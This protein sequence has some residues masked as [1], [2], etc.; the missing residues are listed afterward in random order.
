MFI[1]DTFKREARRLRVVSVVM[2]AGFLALLAG[3]WFVQIV[4]G[5]EMRGKMEWQSLKTNAV[6]PVRGRILDRT[7][8]NVL[9]ENQPRYNVVLYLEELRSQFE[10]EYT[11][12]VLP[13]YTNRLVAEYLR[14]HPGPAQPPPAAA[15][16]PS[17]A[18]PALRMEA[19][20]NVVSNIS[21]RVGLLLSQ[22]AAPVALDP[23]QFRRFYTNYTYEPMLILTNLNPGQIAVFS[24]QLSGQ[25]G[26]ELDTQPV[27]FYPH[28]E[29]AAHLLG[30]VQRTEESA[31]RRYLPAEYEGE[32]GL[33]KAFDDLLH[34]EP[35]SDLVLVNNE[36]YRQRQEVLSPNQYGWDLCL[37]LDLAVQ[38]AAEK[39]LAKSATLRGAAV[40]MDVRSGDILA[41]ASAP[42]FDPNE[43]VSGISLARAGQLDDPKLKPQVNRA[44]FDAYPPGS[45]FK[46]ITALAG[47][48]SGVLDPEAVYHS[49]PNPL[50]PTQG[51]FEEEGYR[52]DDTAPPGDYNF[53]RAFYHSSNAYFC[54]YGMKTGLRKLLEVAGRFHLG[55]KTGF[56]TRE[57]VAGAVPPPEQAGRKM[58][59]NS[60]PYVAIGQE[61]TVTPLQMTVLIA[62]IANGGAIFWPRLVTHAVSPE[63]GDVKELFPKARVRDQVRLDP[64]HLQI[65]R[66][67]ML[68][69]T[70]HP[71]A[72]AYKEFHSA[73]GTPD[74]PN[75]H[76]AGKTGTAEV[77][78]PELDYKKVTWFASYGPYENPR[79]AV[80][81][82]VLDGGSGGGTCAPVALEIYKTI[83]KQELTSQPK[84]ALA[85]R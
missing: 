73:N 6:P 63:T 56:A 61:I 43:F 47:L 54:H 48:E 40:V 27:R 7:A 19:K 79:Y 5:K 12:H 59:L 45:T 49:P 68:Q 50:K 15:K 60:A 53:E 22:T 74:L 58:P 31:G 82:M 77:K 66:Q 16:L 80:V 67:A 29:T 41:M 72:T 51:I 28:K 2:A 55:E 78:S 38:Q 21:S 36:N 83:V 69:D 39:A 11:N 8:T 23:A 46:I 57:E 71:D 37:T 75:F 62:A 65:I 35:G 70:E 44:T 52:I 17:G 20:Y 10:G 1:F 30:Y 84:P 34:G 14:R 42:A 32:R 4:S 81:V 13:D 24:E 25:P 3:L 33:E 64:R 26:I 85:S 76:V 9:A 18:R